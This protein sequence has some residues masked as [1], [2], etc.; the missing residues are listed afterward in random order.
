MAKKTTLEIH[1]DAE[2]KLRETRRDLL[3]GAKSLA[4]SLRK[5]VSAMA[6]M[7]RET[8][9]HLGELERSLGLFD[10]AEKAL[11][12][13]RSKSLAMMLSNRPTSGTSA[14]SRRSSA[15]AT[16]RSRKSAPA[17]KPSGRE[18][19]RERRS[20]PSS[21]RAS[22]SSSKK[23]ASAKKLARRAVQSLSPLRS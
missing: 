9:I 15:P 12:T 19:R 5:D 7:S 17:T 6:T 21:K 23:R 4:E 11:R 20:E 8:E 22:T 3:R 13:A 16:S 2:L 1:I 18:L 10:R 14:A